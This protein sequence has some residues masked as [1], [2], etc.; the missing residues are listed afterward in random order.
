MD[1]NG[2]SGL[3]FIAVALVVITAFALAWAISLS[4]VHPQATISSA[5]Y[6]THRAFLCT[7]LL[8]VF[9]VGFLATVF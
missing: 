6:I 5:K 9:G 1:F 3:I 2:A 7:I 8:A 4:H